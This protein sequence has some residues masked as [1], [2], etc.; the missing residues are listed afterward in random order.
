MVAWADFTCK[1][2]VPVYHDPAN[3]YVV[4]LTDTTLLPDNFFVMGDGSF[5]SSNPNPSY[6]DFRYQLYRRVGESCKISINSVDDDRS[7]C[8]IYDWTLPDCADLEPPAG[9]TQALTGVD[10]CVHQSTPTTSVINAISLLRLYADGLPSTTSRKIE[11]QA[12]GL[13]I[14]T[15]VDGTLDTL[16]N[17]CEWRELTS[18][19]EAATMECLERDGVTY[20]AACCQGVQ[21]KPDDSTD[22]DPDDKINNMKNFEPVSELT[23]ANAVSGN[24]FGN[25]ILEPPSVTSYDLTFCAPCEAGKYQGKKNMR[26]CEA[27]WQI[28]SD[29]LDF[30]SS[31]QY[32]TSGDRQRCELASEACL[33]G[34]R[35]NPNTKTCR[36][37]PVNTYI[38][39]TAIENNIGYLCQTCNDP[40]DANGHRLGWQFSGAASTSCREC[41]D[42]WTSALLKRQPIDDGLNFEVGLLEDVIQIQE[43]AYNAL[44]PCDYCT[45]ADVS[46]D[47]PC[48]LTIDDG[49][50][51][52][53]SNELW[54]SKMF[55]AKDEY[56]VPRATATVTLPTFGMQAVAAALNPPQRCELCPAGKFNQGIFHLHPTYKDPR[57]AL[58]DVTDTHSTNAA[59]STLVLCQPCPYCTDATCAQKYIYFSNTQGATTCTRCGIEPIEL[60][61]VTLNADGAPRGC[62]SECDPGEGYDAGT[63]ECVLCGTGVFVNFYSKEGLPGG[64]CEPCEA[65][66]FNTLPAQTEC[67]FCED[68]PVGYYFDNSLGSP[69]ECTPDTMCQVCPPCEAGKIRVGCRNSYSSAGTDKIGKC[70]ADLLVPTR[71]AHRPTAL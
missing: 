52:A 58:M 69:G 27:C 18:V 29:G 23:R 36:E 44:G 48:L 19:A 63:Q 66:K 33:D 5:L 71:S 24:N 60:A 47:E 17:F 39:V 6:A 20:L 30:P 65:G 8:V 10:H 28:G 13:V 3:V 9:N 1:E 57:Q 35:I 32:I 25:V 22:E 51:S 59:L 34:Y 62:E 12:R 54:V 26:N 11:L 21:E 38:D 68:C 40:S 64:V 16:D 7:G 43:S 61:T 2:S 41:I 67:K 49:S 70:S 46:H 31:Q 50:G 56:F 37:C 15:G 45:R 4:D 53:V 55:C 14:G 42:P